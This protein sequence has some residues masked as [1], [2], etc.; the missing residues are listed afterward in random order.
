MEVLAIKG[1]ST[2]PLKTPEPRQYNVHTTGHVDLSQEGAIS[3]AS[4]ISNIPPGMKDSVLA[5]NKKI[6]FR[7]ALEL[8]ECFDT[9]NMTK[10]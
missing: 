9:T 6:V 3:A 7:C 4:C 8:H 5:L 10:E 1:F 2:E